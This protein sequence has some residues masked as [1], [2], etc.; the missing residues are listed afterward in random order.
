MREFLEFVK[1][2]HN[3]DLY[4]FTALQT[5]IERFV[6]S[7]VSPEKKIVDINYYAAINTFIK[8]NAD[9][10]IIVD[11]PILKNLDLSNF[12]GKIRLQG[13]NLKDLPA[14]QEAFLN[15]KCVLT[16]D[17][18]DLPAN[19]IANF[20]LSNVKA[21]NLD[22]S[23]KEQREALRLNTFRSVILSEINAKTIQPDTNKLKNKNGD[24][25][26][27]SP[28][29]RDYS[30]IS[31][32]TNPQQQ[33]L[34]DLAPDNYSRLYTFKNFSNSTT[35]SISKK[36]NSPKSP[37]LYSHFQLPQ[38]SSVKFPKKDNISDNI[39]ASCTS[40]HK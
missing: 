19:V 4:D 24:T 39:D 7:R 28:T 31:S 21:I 6:L 10:T 15:S 36:E 8:F 40:A 37:K 35:K 13:F 25:T 30:Q 32:S 38:F 26:P 33:K 27:S 11:P 17:K 34:E 5:T 14:L 16:I 23:S 1:K 18:N 29:K 20:Y 2:N 22:K 12:P 9:C 3:E